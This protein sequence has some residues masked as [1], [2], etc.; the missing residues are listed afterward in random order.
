MGFNGYYRR[1]IQDF[2]GLSE[3]LVALTRKGFAFAWTDRQQIAF[4]ALKTCLL[5]SPILGFPT[6]D[7]RFILDTDAS[8]FAVGGVLNQLQD[9]REVVIAYTSRSLCQRRYCTTRREML[10]AVVMCTP[11]SVVLTGSPVHLAYGP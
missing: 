7:G 3:P 8:L 2:A 4:D 9:D 6:E 10:A 11:F 1:F 5:N